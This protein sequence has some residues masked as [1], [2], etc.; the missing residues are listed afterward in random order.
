M[1]KSND[2][3]KRFTQVNWPGTNWKDA[4]TPETDQR[5]KYYNQID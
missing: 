5:T 2:Y 3:V 1:A 4:I